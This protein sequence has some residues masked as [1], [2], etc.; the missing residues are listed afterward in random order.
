LIPAPAAEP[1]DVEGVANGINNLGEVSGESLTGSRWEGTVWSGATKYTLKPARFISSATGF[2]INDSGVVVGQGPYEK[3]G[4]FYYFR[5]GVWEA[6][7]SDMILLDGFLTNNSPFL[8]LTSAN[9]VNAGGDIA[10]G[11]WTGEFKAY[12]AIRRE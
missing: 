1:L 5:A 7:Q 2:D 3:R 9:A 4:V 8:N 10:G 11:G 12:V 6:P